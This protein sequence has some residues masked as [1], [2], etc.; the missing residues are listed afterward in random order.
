MPWARTRTAAAWASRRRAPGFVAATAARLRRLDDVVELAL[1][2]AEAAVGGEGARHVARI[3][4]ELAAG[5]DQAQLARLQRRRARRV[6]EDAGVRAGGDDRA[7]RPALRRP[8]AGTR[9]A[10]RPRSRIRG[11]PRADPGA[12]RAAQKRIA[13]TCAAAL[14]ARRAAHRRRSRR[15]SLRTRIVASSGARSCC[16]AGR[17]DAHPALRANA[18]EPAVDA[19]AEAGRVEAPPDRGLIGEALGDDLVEA[20]ER[21]RV[22]DAE[23]CRR[24]VGAEADAVPELALDVLRPARERRPAVAADDE[25]R[26][27]LGEA[28]E[29]VEV[30]AVPV[31]MV[32]V[33]VALTLGRGR[34]DGDAAA[35][36]SHRRG[37]A[38]PASDEGRG[39]RGHSWLRL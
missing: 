37:D 8:S 28:G 9:A 19:R 39:S 24:R 22:V 12:K 36:L 11:W 29:V 35:G 3:A 38:G 10:A 27:G 4:V 32:V 33:A 6:V 30:A 15:A 7:C 17:L 5:V 14:I 20:V 23:R 13:R 16:D 26:A 1:R 25:P 21:D 2:R 34:H 18:L 31:R